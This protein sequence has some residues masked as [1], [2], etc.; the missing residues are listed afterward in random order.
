M[1]GSGEV[2]TFAQLESRS[3]QVARLLQSNGLV[4]GDVVGLCMD[5][6]S[7][8][9]EIALGIQRV[10]L[11]FVPISTKLLADEIAYILK[12]SG[13]KVVF[14]SPSLGDVAKTLRES[15]LDVIQWYAV[16]GAIPGFQD[17]RA[18]RDLQSAAPFSGPAPG[19]YL[20]YSSG[21]TGRPK[22]IRTIMEVTANQAEHPLMRILGEMFRMDENTLYLSPA[23]IYHSA[24][25]T[26][27]LRVLRAGGTCLLVE[28]F[29]AEAVLKIIEK[30]K[31]THAQFVPTMFVRFLK[32]P[33]EV[34][35]RYDMS[36]MR[37]AI[38]A[39]APC[40]VEVKEQMIS[41]W[42]PIISE[43]YGA[44]EGLGMTALNSEDW[45]NHKGS[46]GRPIFG[47]LHILDDEGIEL[48]SGQSGAIWF[49]K[50][51]K[52]E[53]LHDPD[54]TAS[55]ANSRGWRTVGDV[56][57]VDSEGFLYLT[58]RK[59]NLIIS[60][61]VNIYPQETEDLILTHP[62]V[63]DAAVFGVPNVEMG[64]E[65][66]AV[67][68]L[69][70]PREASADLARVLIEFCRARLSP[71]KC[72]KSIDFEIDLPRHPNGKLYKRKL[73]DRYWQGRTSKII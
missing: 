29:D 42:G 8:W 65:V 35:R 24:P 9:H 51:G 34:R 57:Y 61:G 48:P 15:A 69:V 53:Y 49:E 50:G 55:S 1:A 63:M 10:G 22:G 12:D 33:A 31:V 68:Q 46:V 37:H 23:P 21:T 18:V 25:L 72:P 59:A 32:L 66:K 13:A 4:P 44:T 7:H 62:K 3:G 58:D 47:K 60:G 39:A 14:A 54:K 30:Y 11:M 5:T 2:V 73:R 52:F 67:V 36:S 26:W 28:K 43:F 64:E 38:H 40:P 70:D 19:T 41:W 56:G 71:I 6:N 17:Y 27:T 20:I 16:D 45:L